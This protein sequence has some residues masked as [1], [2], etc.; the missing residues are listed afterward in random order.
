MK[1]VFIICLT[2]NEGLTLIYNSFTNSLIEDTDG[3][4]MQ[5][6]NSLKTIEEDSSKFSKEEINILQKNGII[7]NDTTDQKE[8]AIKTQ[9]RR[10]EKILMRKI[11]WDSLLHLL[12]HAISNV[13]T[14]L[15]Q[16]R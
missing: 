12:W 6:V 15:K 16:T 7:T 13:F 10:L 14:V 2:D 3:R 8:L 1:K 9:K 5:F 11:N 4:I